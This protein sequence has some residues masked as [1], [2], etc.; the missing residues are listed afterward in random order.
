MPRDMATSGP[1]PI[2]VHAGARMRARR[3]ALG[4]SQQALADKLGVSFQQIQKYERGANRISFS[5]LV[6]SAGVMGID[7]AFFAEGLGKVDGSAKLSIDPASEF[8]AEDGAHDMA[9]AYVGLPYGHKRVVRDMVRGL[10]S[11]ST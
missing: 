6:R 2:D 10:A 8:F 1:D 5:T 3:K 9:T 7:I 11:A 4:M